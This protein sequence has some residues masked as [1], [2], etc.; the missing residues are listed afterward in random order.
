MKTAAKPVKPIRVTT[1]YLTE[2]INAKLEEWEIDAEV[3]H[4][5]RTHYRSHE[6]EAGAACLNIWLRHKK[7]KWGN[8]A[9]FFAFFS[10][11]TMTHYLAQGYKLAIKVKYPM[12]GI[13][14]ENWEL[15]VER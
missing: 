14:E 4:I 1:K 2:W 7:G 11:G 13:S 9:L 6:Y 5:T 10:M 15:T 12:F 8:N 3:D